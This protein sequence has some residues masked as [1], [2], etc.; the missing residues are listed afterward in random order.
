MTDFMDNKE[1]TTMLQQYLVNISQGFER[2][3]FWVTILGYHFGSTFL[4]Q[5]FTPNFLH[6]VFFKTLFSKI[7]NWV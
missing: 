4:H 3:T 2:S 6:H 7:Q 5:I 1:V